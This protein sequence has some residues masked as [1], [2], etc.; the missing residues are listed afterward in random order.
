M[1]GPDQVEQ[2]P[3]SLLP[4]DAPARVEYLVATVLG[5]DLRE[6][7]QLGIGRI[8]AQSAEHLRQILDLRLR[9][10]QAEL[11][12]G[13][14][15]RRARILAQDH[16]RQGPRP[17][18]LQQFGRGAIRI[19]RDLGHAVVQRLLQPGQRIGTEA[20]RRA[21]TVPDAALD[22]GNPLEPAVMRDVG[23]F[24]GPWRDG[25]D[26]GHHQHLMLGA[27]RRRR[28]TVFEQTAQ[29]RQLGLR[30]SAVTLDQV[31]EL[32]GQVAHRR[33]DRAQRVEQP[34]A[35]RACQRGRTVQ[36]QK[37]FA[38]RAHAAEL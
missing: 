26:S 31:P 19:G 38:I 17:P 25:A 29:P 34:G 24:A 10:G 18:A 14:L 12:V 16:A 21:Q 37:D 9:Q 30:G 22:A 36:E 6:H 3:A 4:V 1:G 8:A 11:P 33:L 35:A 2:R 13:A 20:P 27:R 15:Q 32:P 23:G 5:I 28:L 7:H